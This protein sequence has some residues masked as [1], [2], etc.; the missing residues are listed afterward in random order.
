MVFTG[1]VL[2]QSNLGNVASKYNIYIIL[3]QEGNVFADLK[4]PTPAPDAY[5]SN[6]NKIRPVSP[7][8]KMT[9]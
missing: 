1:H 5:T 6:I 2:L 7:S 8:Y 4:N 9:T 3:F